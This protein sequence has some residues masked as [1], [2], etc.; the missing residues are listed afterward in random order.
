MISWLTWAMMRERTVVNRM[1]SRITPTKSM[2]I[3]PIM[4]TS[5][6]GTATS[7]TH[8]VIFGMLREATLAS[9][10][11]HSAQIICTLCLPM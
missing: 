3:L 7:S 11:R 10:D 4:A 8:S 9:A 1:L 5:A 2:A 6:A